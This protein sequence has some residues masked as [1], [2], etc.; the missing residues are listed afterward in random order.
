[1]NHVIVGLGSNIEPEKN[2][3][4]ARKILARKYR[5]LAESSFMTTKPIGAIQQTDFVNG[6]VLLETELTRR[7]LK[8]AFKEIESDLGRRKSHDPDTPR[9]IDLDIVVW[10]ENVVD[11]DF[12]DRDYLKRSVLELVPDLKYKS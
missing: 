5:I 12:Y 6:A 4:R 10:N 9:T 7:Q 1:M 3:P 2:I 11:K 8:K